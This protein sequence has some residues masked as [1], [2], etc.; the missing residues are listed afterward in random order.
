MMER[1]DTVFCFFVI[2]VCLLMIALICSISIIC[3]IKDELEQARGADPNVIPINLLIKPAEQKWLASY[4]D[5]DKTQV[6]YNLRLLSEIDTNV[7]AKLRECEA[8]IKALEDPN[9]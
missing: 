3:N 1:K 7:I 8:R 6:F 5:S 9:K 4:G 2:L